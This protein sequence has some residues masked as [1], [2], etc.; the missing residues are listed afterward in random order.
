[1]YPIGMTIDIF[2]YHG[3]FG[4]DPDSVRNEILEGEAELMDDKP[5]SPDQ[6]K[7]IAVN[8]PNC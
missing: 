7:L 2:V 3:K 4:Y 1:M 6:V 8:C 5:V